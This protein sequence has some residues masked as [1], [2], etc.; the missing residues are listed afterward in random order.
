[1]LQQLA[2]EAHRLSVQ[3]AE[4]EAQ[5]HYPMPSLAILRHARPTNLEATLYEPVICLI[6]QGRK[7]TTLGDRTVAFGAGQCLLVSHD[8]PVVSRVTQAPYVA[9]VVRLDLATLRSLHDEVADAGRAS[10]PAR[11]MDVHDADPAL[12]DALN[13]YLSLAGST[14]DAKVLGPLILKELHYRLLAAPFGG[15]LRALIQH[16]S[17][18]SAV[19]RAIGHI[20]REFRAPIEVPDLARQVGMSVSAFHKHFKAITATTP[21]QYQKELRL[22]EA[23][24]ILSSGNPSVTSVAFEVGYESPN[25]FSREYARKFGVPP[26]RDVATSAA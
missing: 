19:E 13:R 2:R 5:I 9:L 25:Q 23:R 18:A 6:V 4:N 26:S 22:L 7:E 15:M 10:M 14:T 24:R 16:D 11:T 12:L 3:V 1:M 17:H 20:R 21:L 8:V